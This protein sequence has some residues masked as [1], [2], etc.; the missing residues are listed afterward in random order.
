MPV[1][2]YLI[3]TTPGTT[4]HLVDAFRRGLNEAGSAEG[5]NVAIEFRFAEGHHDQLPTLAA[6][7][8]GRPT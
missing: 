1:I 7:L 6:E 8:V 2:G 4:A 3:A 5:Q